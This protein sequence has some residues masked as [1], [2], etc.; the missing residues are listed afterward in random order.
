VEVIEGKNL[1]AKKD[2]KSDP[3]VKI[4]LNGVKKRTL[5][6]WGNLNPVWNEK[7]S[8][9]VDDIKS[10]EISFVCL[11]YEKFIKGFFICYY[12]RF[13]LESFSWCCTIVEEDDESNL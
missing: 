4:E 6:Q 8:F 12:Y 7:F 11:D 5:V 1:V 3:F 2:G 9:Y 10:T 13:M